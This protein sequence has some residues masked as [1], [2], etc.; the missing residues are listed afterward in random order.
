M[1]SLSYVRSDIGDIHA[2][3]Q[4]IDFDKRDGLRGKLGGRIGGIEDF[5]GSKVSFYLQASYVHE[6]KGKDGLNFLSGG[7]NQ[8]IN[9][10]RP[11]DYGQGALGVNIFSTGRASGFVEAD[12]DVGGG[13]TGGGGRVGLSFKL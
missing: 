10:V 1:A 3:D 4:T 9:G 2:F 5:G 12:A 7:I 11:G 13:V 8:A 6:F